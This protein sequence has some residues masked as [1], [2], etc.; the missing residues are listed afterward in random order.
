[1]KQVKSTSKLAEADYK[2]AEAAYKEGYANATEEILDELHDALYGDLEH[3]VAWLNDKA[4]TDF[5]TSYPS[6]NKFVGWLSDLEDELTEEEEDN[7]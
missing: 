1:M 6:L 5:A 7:D 3:G 2:L 4:A